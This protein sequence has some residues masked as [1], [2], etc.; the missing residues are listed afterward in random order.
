MLQG[1]VVASATLQGFEGGL[2]NGSRVWGWPRRQHSFNS[3]N[4]GGLDASRDWS[5][6]RGLIDVPPHVEELPEFSPE[7]PMLLG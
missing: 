3:V 6:E 2:G 4:L 5:G 1:F 7:C